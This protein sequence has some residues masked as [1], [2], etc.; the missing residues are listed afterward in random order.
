MSRRAAPDSDIGMPGFRIEDGYKKEAGV[1]RDQG[2]RTSV[3]IALMIG[4]ALAVAPATAHAPVSA[5]AGDVF[6]VDT[7]GASG[8]T[9]VHAMS[10]A[11]NFRS[12]SLHPATDLG[13]ARSE[14]VDVRLR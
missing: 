3:A 2:L 4:G 8:M 5:G 14:P 12:F 6:A 7:C 11:G 10:R 13:P 1:W 9:E